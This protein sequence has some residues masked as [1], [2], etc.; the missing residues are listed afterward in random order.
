MS[1]S[2]RFPAPWTVDEANDASFIVRDASGQALGT[3]NCALRH[4]LASVWRAQ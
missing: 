1:K 3:P 2:R 4:I